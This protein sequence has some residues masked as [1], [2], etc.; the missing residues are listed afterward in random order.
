MTTL[1]FGRTVAE[2]RRESLSIVAAPPG[3]IVLDRDLRIVSVQAAAPLGRVGAADA[4]L[5]LAAVDPDV[6][7]EL[8]PA[9][10]RVLETGSAESGLEIDVATG[11]HV[12]SLFPAAG[13]AEETVICVFAA[14]PA[15]GGPADMAA[16]VETAGDAIVSMDLR[17]II[18][19][20][21]RGAERLYGYSA[22]EAI[23]RRIALVEPTVRPQQ[24]SEL[25][26]R[27]AAGHA[28]QLRE[29]AR[30]R[31]DGARIDVWVT[32]APVHAADGSLVGI[33]EIGRDVTGRRRNQR[34]TER[35][36][37]ESERRRRQGLASMLHAEEVER[38]RIATELHDDTVQV[39]IASM[40]AMD[41]AALV[42]QKTGSAQLESAVSVARATLEEATDRTRRL[43]F[44]LRPAVLL[45]D[46]LVAA[47]RVLA[48]QVGRE[49][50]ASAR[51][52]GAVARYD[53]SIEELVY[54]SVQ[55]AL[56]NVRKHARP[57][58]IAVTLDEHR[59]MIRAE[60]CDDGRGF[61]IVDARSRP[62]SA[63]HL[64]LDA[65]QERVGAVGGT[66]EIISSHG[67][68]TCVRLSVPVAGFECTAGGRHP[69]AV[70]L[71]R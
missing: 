49:T 22:A 24:W 44:E 48:Q 52:R 3:M 5:M 16:I 58:A 34:R 63:L 4:G 7:R 59:G 19:S 35:A 18:R 42:A 68:G 2:D 56:A 54:R 67:K 55:E 62:Q 40:M 29:A 28:D 53:H 31:K 69:T 17:G 47:V 30:S 70:A 26:R 32:A 50:G 43:M 12:L 6:H 57:D 27:I 61:D 10:A 60:I 14:A 33:A 64:G 11:R 25:T 51:V 1:R 39:M 46:G 38:S 15:P 41:R 20:W 21:N 37:R 13:A 9:V 66:V 23:G 45:R 65:L 71:D 36:L 8:A